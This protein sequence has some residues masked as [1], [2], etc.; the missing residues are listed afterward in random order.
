[1]EL[2]ILKKN[3]IMIMKNSKILNINIY[4]IKLYLY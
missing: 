2:I 3:K 1:M 4:T